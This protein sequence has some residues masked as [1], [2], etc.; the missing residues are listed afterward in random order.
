MVEAGRDCV[1]GHVVH[2]P[3]QARPLA[4]DHV[5]MAF[6]YLQGRRLHNHPEQPAPV[7]RHPH[8]K[9]AFPDGQREPPVLQFVPIA[10]GLVK[11]FQPSTPS[12]FLAID[13]IQ[14]VVEYCV[15]L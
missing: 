4:Q 9:K 1:G 8:T 12:S 15:F 14:F 2:T 10:S 6:E 3:A 13:K 7:L 11:T 5:Q